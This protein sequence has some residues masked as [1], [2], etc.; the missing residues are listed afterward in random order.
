[1]DIVPPADDPKLERRSSISQYKG[2]LSVEEKGEWVP[3]VFDSVDGI[4][5]DTMKSHKIMIA[6]EPW[7]GYPFEVRNCEYEEEVYLMGQEEG[8]ELKRLPEEFGDGFYRSKYDRDVIV[9]GKDGALGLHTKKTL[10][11]GTDYVWGN[12]ELE[13]AD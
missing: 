8:E 11:V 7:I 10:R 4:L 3:I 6:L 5:C 1:M 13:P 9:S 2:M 12:D